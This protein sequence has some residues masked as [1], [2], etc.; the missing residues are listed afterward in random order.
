VP[1][2]DESKLSTSTLILASTLRSTTDKDIGASF[3]IGGAKVIPNLSGIYR[4]GQEV[5]VYLQVYNAKIDQT[6]LRPA[7]DVEYILTK[8]GKEVFKQKED[9]QGLSDAGQ[10]LTLARLLPTT[11]MPLGDYELKIKIR[12]NVGDKPQEVEQTAKFTVSQ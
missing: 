4:K 5:G 7:V 3:V 6:T 9:W 8:G 10:R 1:R 11:Q 2:Y 12:D